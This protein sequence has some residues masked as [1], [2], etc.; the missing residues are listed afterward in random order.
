M[1]RSS[2][3]TEEKNTLKNSKVV[4]SNGDVEQAEQRFVHLN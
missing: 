3:N 4:V 2:K 1:I